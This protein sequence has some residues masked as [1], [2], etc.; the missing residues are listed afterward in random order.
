MK[1]HNRSPS[2]LDA[3]SFVAIY[4]GVY[5]HS[6]WVAESV[7]AEGL[8]SAD[9]EPAALAS[10]M[11]DVVEASGADRQLELLQLHPE[12]A[13][14]TGI[15][16][17]L[18]E[19]SK[20]EQSGARLDQCSPEEFERFQSLNE[21]YRTK[22]GFP[23]IIAVTGLSRAEILAAFEKRVGNSRQVELRTALVQVHKIARIR[24][25][26]I[27]RLHE[28]GANKTARTTA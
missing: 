20:R 8:T 24:I 19:S 4:G 6:P 10:R 27:A 18:T 13:S 15:A 5:E 26:A 25:D 28:P 2:Q 9:D 16:E 3:V 17:D 12:L 11:A 23:F 21:A 7:A 1:V 22:F 14:K